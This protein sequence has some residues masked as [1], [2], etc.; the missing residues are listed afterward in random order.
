MTELAARSTAVTRVLKSVPTP[1][2]PTMAVAEPMEKDESHWSGACSKLRYSSTGEAASV[3]AARIS[4]FADLLA[5]TS[6]RTSEPVM[7]PRASSA[8]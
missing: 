5:V 7:Q 3:G 8:R 4:M 1:A 6:W 2:S